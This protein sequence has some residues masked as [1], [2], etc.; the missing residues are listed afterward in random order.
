MDFLEQSGLI[1][2]F[3]FRAITSIEHTL[4]I[5]MVTDT[6]VH[7]YLIYHTSTLFLSFKSGLSRI[8]AFLKL[9]SVLLELFLTFLYFAALTEQQIVRDLANGISYANF[10]KH[11]KSR[12][13]TEQ[14][15]SV[16][17]KSSTECGGKC[18]LSETCL[19]VNYGGVGGHECQLLAADK[20][21]S[22]EKM[23]VDENFQHFSVA[24][25]EFSM[26][27]LLNCILKYFTDK[28]SRR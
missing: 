13:D 6:S 8:M 15:A 27:D 25:S 24:V 21:D 11:D 9:F 12:L 1:I 2:N 16:T 5:S 14:L 3:L 23:T 22:S 17:A 19:S 28:Y 20:F 4:N 18:L 7:S 26:H 10:A